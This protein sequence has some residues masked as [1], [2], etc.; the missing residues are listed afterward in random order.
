MI[1]PGLESR[2]YRLLA[3]R[4]L[5]LESET[6]ELDNLAADQ[7]VAK[8]LYTAVSVGTE[9]AAYRGDPPLRP[10]LSVY[11]RLVGYCNVAEVVQTGS[12]AKRFRAGVRILTGQSHR[13]A[14][15]IEEAAAFCAVPEGMDDVDA[16]VAYLFHL[17]YQAV[18]DTEVSRGRRVGVIGLGP[19]G[20]AASACARLL[21]AH[22]TGVSARA[23]TRKVLKSIGAS[24]VSRDEATQGDGVDTV[25]LTSNKWEDWRLA[26]E[27]AREGAT[28]A[29]LGFP[30]RGQPAPD[31][32]PLDSRWFY[33]KRLSIRSV[34]PPSSPDELRKNLC[35]LL[36]KIGERQLD[37]K[38]LVSRIDAASGL[39]EVYRDL[40]ENRGD[41]VT[42]V[43]DWNST[44]DQ[45]RG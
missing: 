17:G 34:G 4:E 27:M 16:C 23:S 20:I 5:R 28:I 15:K 11:P 36:E 26:L 24:V 14:F 13:S 21:E 40:D 45:R 33:D 1:G 25:I 37:P 41:V 19:L 22:V 29:T 44:S 18:L 39:G 12:D 32:N 7:I 6:I 10:T 9:L 35:F 38:L 3:P 8:T 43:L 30:G 42:V 31:F 2:V